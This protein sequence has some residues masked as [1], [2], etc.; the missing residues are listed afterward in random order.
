VN[1]PE[2]AIDK[3]LSGLEVGFSG[4]D[5]QILYALGHACQSETLKMESCT[6]VPKFY[7]MDEEIQNRNCSPHF[8][9]SMDFP[10]LSP[11]NEARQPP[12]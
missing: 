6:T 12:I 9:S 4:N 11:W 8:V 7:D 3:I 1:H 5:Q 2:I 10:F